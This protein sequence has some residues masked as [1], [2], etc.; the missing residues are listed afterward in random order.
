MQEMSEIQ[1][2]IFFLVADVEI[3]KNGDMINNNCETP[4]FKTLGCMFLFT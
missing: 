2:S 1:A 3:I 4:E